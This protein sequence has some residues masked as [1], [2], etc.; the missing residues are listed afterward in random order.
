MGLPD[1][2]RTAMDVACPS[3]HWNL[4]RARLALVACSKKPIRR[5]QESTAKTHFRG[6]RGGAG[7]NHRDDEAH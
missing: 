3:S 2:V 6:F 7:P 4:F 1:S 5:R